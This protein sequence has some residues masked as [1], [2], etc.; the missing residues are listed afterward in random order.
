MTIVDVFDAALEGNVNEFYR[1]FDSNVNQ[2]NKYTRLNLL[3]TVV[4]DDTNA[5]GRIKIIKTLLFR[6]I[7]A[8]FIDSKFK[9]NALHALFFSWSRQSPSFVYDAA[10][11]LIEYGVDLNATDKFNSIP[12]KYAIT[13][14][15]HPTDELKRVYL[16]LLENGSDY[17]SKDIFGK[18]CLDYAEEYSWRNDF[19]DIVKEFE[20][21]KY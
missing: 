20:N 17:C 9:R 7:D 5:E 10:E 12:L 8:T 15:K 1:Y 14:P 2:V 13:V 6:G 16:L 3:S 19:I 11:L 18:S 4:L 21:D